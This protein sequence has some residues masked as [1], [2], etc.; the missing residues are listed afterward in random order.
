MLVVGDCLQHPM[1]KFPGQILGPHEVDPFLCVPDL[2]DTG[3]DNPFNVIVILLVS[4]TTYCNRDTEG[5]IAG[6]LNRRPLDF[7]LIIQ[8]GQEIFGGIL[9]FPAGNRI[10]LR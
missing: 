8:G 7:R 1:D 3:P 4:R 6:D 9:H 2:H 10:V 5:G